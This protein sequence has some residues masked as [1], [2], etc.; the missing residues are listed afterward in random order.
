MTG[1]PEAPSA[2]QIG[3]LQV[4]ALL[5]FP[6]QRHTKASTLLRVIL[7]QHTKTGIGNADDDDDINEF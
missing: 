3:P 6:H 4:R 2:P 7:I 5:P 1:C